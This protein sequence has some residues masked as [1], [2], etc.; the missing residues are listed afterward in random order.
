MNHVIEVFDSETEELLKTVEIPFARQAE[1]IAL[2]GWKEPDDAIY[3]YDL[4]PEQL[5]RIEEWTGTQLAGSNNIIQLACIA[6]HK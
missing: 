6:T 4:S 2:M 3:V 5:R 1:L